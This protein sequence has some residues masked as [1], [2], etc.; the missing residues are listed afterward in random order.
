MRYLNVLGSAIKHWWPPIV[1]MVL[2]AG[3]D[4][5]TTTAIA[6]V[7]ALLSWAYWKGRYGGEW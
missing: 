1:L 5:T 7:V 2:L 4:V 6:L 3:F